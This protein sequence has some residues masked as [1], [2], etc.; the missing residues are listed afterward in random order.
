MSD[1]DGV[2]A[3]EDGNTLEMG[4]SDTAHWNTLTTSDL[5]IWKWLKW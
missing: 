5:H 2:S 1:G 4:G 3:W